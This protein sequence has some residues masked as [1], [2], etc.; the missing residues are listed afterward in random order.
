MIRNRQVKISDCEGKKENVR[1][2]NSPDLLRRER[3]IV[4]MLAATTPHM[5][6]SVS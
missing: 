2:S 6:I 1:R 3:V 4:L 5:K